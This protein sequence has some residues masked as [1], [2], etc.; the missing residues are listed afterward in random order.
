MG[1]SSA[2][3]KL[4]ETILAE[5]MSTLD[6]GVDDPGI[7]KMIFFAGGPGSGKSFAASEIFGLQ[8]LKGEKDL[9]TSFSSTGL[10]VVNSDDMFIHMLK[11][12]G[13]SPK[14]FADISKN[15][16]ALAIKIG[17]QGNS[18]DSIRSKAKAVVARMRAMF[19][20]GRLGMIIDGTGHLFTKIAK[21]RKIAEAMGYDTYMVFVNTSL[22]VALAR[23]AKRDRT[24]PE[25]I[26]RKSWKD[27]QSN[28][29]K[30]QSLFGAKNIIIVDNNVY[31]PIPAHISK[32]AS[33]FI[34]RPISNK[35]GKDWVTKQRLLKKAGVLAKSNKR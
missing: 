14:D 29:G 1:S 4:K 16:I 18:D 25:E 17:L 7:L 22:E 5:V 12:H 20:R 32:A 28:L 2:L 9:R 21:Q 35:I 13:I 19:M 8:P 33:K 34:S 15:D 11:K 23:N 24:V 3:T 6:E 10:K 26:V 31:G 30:F 27:V